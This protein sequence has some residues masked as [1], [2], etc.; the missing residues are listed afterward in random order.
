MQRYCCA[1][2]TK[3]TVFTADLAHAARL[4]KTVTE[5]TERLLVGPDTEF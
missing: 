5:L 3:A 2:M 1:N 4:D